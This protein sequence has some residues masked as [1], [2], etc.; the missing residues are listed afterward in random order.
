MEKTP[1]KV[2]IQINFV[3]KYLS[4]AKAIAAKDRL[5]A[6]IA[7]RLCF[8]VLQYGLQDLQRESKQDKVQIGKWIQQTKAFFDESKD[9]R[10][11]L[12]PVAHFNYGFRADS[13]SVLISKGQLKDAYDTCLTIFGNYCSLFRFEQTDGELLAKDHIETTPER[14]GTQLLEWHHHRFQ[15]Y[16]NDYPYVALVHFRVLMEGYY[17]IEWLKAECEKGASITDSITEVNKVVKLDELAR[18]NSQQGN[19]LD[20]KVYVYF[21]R[22]L[23]FSN[24]KLNDVCKPFRLCKTSDHESTLGNLFE[25]IDTDLEDLVQTWLPKLIRGWKQYEST[26]QSDSS[27]IDA[28]TLRGTEKAMTQ[29]HDSGSRPGVAKKTLLALVAVVTVLS[30]ILGSVGVIVSKAEPTSISKKFILN[31][32]N[33]KADARTVGNMAREELSKVAA[34]EGCTLQLSTLKNPT[35]SVGDGKCRVSASAACK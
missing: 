4:F 13:T 24:P 9:K 2:Q 1:S 33:G 10:P 25:V 21:G 12:D 11:P 14:R 27:P 22:I 29:M 31:C 5:S 17:K 23:A 18:K 3:E 6:A 30:A 16:R 19:E 26:E 8:N 34:R 7:L 20:A 35:T 28:G 15:R 32:P